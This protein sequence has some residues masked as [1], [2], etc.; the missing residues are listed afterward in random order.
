MDGNVAG[1]ISGAH[2]EDVIDHKMNASFTG[3][4]RTTLPE[5]RHDYTQAIMDLG[6]TVVLEKPLCLYCR[7]INIIPEYINKG[8]TGT[9]IQKVKRSCQNG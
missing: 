9:A 6:A 8:Q 1:I 5:Q 4:C 7:C 3:N 2:I